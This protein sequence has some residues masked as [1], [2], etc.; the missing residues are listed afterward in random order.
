MPSLS[1]SRDALKTA[2]DRLVRA[3]RRVFDYAA[4]QNAWTSAQN[5]ELA[6]L[7]EQV[8]RARKQ[9]DQAIHDLARALGGDDE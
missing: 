6:K 9:R 7:R 4:E 2:T 8:D 5:A 1:E 3:E